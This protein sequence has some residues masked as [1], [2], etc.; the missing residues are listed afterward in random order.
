MFIANP[1]PERN[2]LITS[3]VAKPNAPK[4][5]CNGPRA[6]VQTTGEIRNVKKREA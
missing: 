2:S 5:T 4:T 1:S 3:P 6:V